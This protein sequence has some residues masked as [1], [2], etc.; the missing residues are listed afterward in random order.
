MIFASEVEQH[1][2]IARPIAMVAPMRDW[3]GSRVRSTPCFV[4]PHLC[5]ELDLARCVQIRTRAQA[6]RGRWINA[7]QC[8]SEQPCGHLHCRSYGPTQSI[9]HSNRAQLQAELR[10]QLHERAR[11]VAGHGLEILGHATR[12]SDRQPF[13][14]LELHASERVPLATEGSR[15]RPPTTDCRVCSQ[16]Q[17]RPTA[18]RP[19]VQAPANEQQRSHKT[20]A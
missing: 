10:T 3:Q 5:T 17:A 9:V 15:A 20:A 14:A 12:L 2:S 19:R 11:S 18:R 13:T 1:P 16:S 8:C 7:A 4:Y 6:P